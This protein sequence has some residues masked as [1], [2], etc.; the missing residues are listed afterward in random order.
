MAVRRIPAG[1]RLLRAPRGLSRKLAARYATCSC[2]PAIARSRR[3]SATLTA[4]P[5]PSGALCLSFRL[6]PM[7]KTHT[8]P[9]PACDDAIA[10]VTRVCALAG[11]A[12]MITDLR[13]AGVLAAVDRHD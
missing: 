1:A 12:S 7:L 11:S 3:R 2:S 13:Q 4:T 5:T 6:E 9:A 10:L 8:A